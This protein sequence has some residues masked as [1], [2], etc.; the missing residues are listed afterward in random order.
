M[1]DIFDIRDRV[2]LVTGASSG[3]GQH[4]AR[5][6]ASRGAR[7]ALAARRQQRLQETVE[8]ITAAGGR[9]LAVSLDVSERDSVRAAFDAIEQAFGPVEVLINNAGVGYHGF[10]MDVSDA[11]WRSVM[12]VDLDGVWACAQEAAQRMKAH[13]VSGNIVNIASIMG[14]GVRKALA[15]YAVAKAGVIQMT[16]A[17]ALELARDNIRVNAIAPGYC[18]TEIN[19][20][21]LDSDAGAK[22]IREIPQKRVGDLAELE[23]PLLLLA[24]GAGSFM[25]GSVLTVDGGHTLSMGPAAG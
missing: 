3:F 11:D 16:R 13:G 9:A 21:F 17:L 23:G 8:E 18:R 4:F 22:L 14:L 24:S 20:D 7:V 6:L 10:A 1:Q 12:A 5:F 15:P 19:H 2:I 25:T